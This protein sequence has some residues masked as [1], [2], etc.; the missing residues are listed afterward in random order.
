MGV[1]N[2]PQARLTLSR[3]GAL[4]EHVSGQNV[5]LDSGGMEWPTDVMVANAA[6]IPI[7]VI[8]DTDGSVTDTLLGA[9]ASAPSSCRTNS[10]TENVDSITPQGYITHAELILNGRCT[11][12]AAAQLQ[13]MQYKLERAIG[14]VLG[15]AWSQVNDNVFTGVPTATYNQA[16]HWPIM[17]PIDIICGPY[18]YQCLPNPFTLRPDDVASMVLLYPLPLANG[19]YMSLQGANALTGDVTFPDGGPMLGVNVLVKREIYS[20]TT[21]D[22]WYEVSGV[23]GPGFRRAGTSVFVTAGMS[24]AASQGTYV[25]LYGGVYKIAYIPLP[26]GASYDNLIVSTE[27]LNPLYVGSYTVGPYGAGMVSP[28]GTMGVAQTSYLVGE[29]SSAE[30]DFPVADAAVA[31]GTGTDGTQSAAAQMAATGWW[32]AMI[33]GYQHA[34]YYGMDVRPERSFTVEATAL[35]AN[36]LAT[37]NKMMPV[38]GVFG[39]ADQLWESPS[40]GVTPAAFQGWSLGTSAITVQTGQ[41]THVSIGV[42]DERGDGRPDFNYQGRMFYADAVE[43]ATVAS[44]GAT[45]TI[46]GMGF[47]AGNAVLVNGVAATVTSWTANALVATLPTMAAAGAS[48]GTALDVTVMDRGT[49]ATSTMYGALTYGSGGKLPRAMILVS[50]PAGVVPVGDVASPV[51]AVRVVLSDGVT[52]VV[53]DKVVFQVASG[54]A[55]FGACGSA[56]CAVYTDATGLAQSSVTPG[57]VGSLT[58]QAGDGTV[59][60]TATLTGQTK[61]ASMVVLSAPTGN[62]QAGATAGTSFTVQVFGADGVTGLGGHEIS[63]TVTQGSATYDACQAAVCTAMTD[64]YGRVSMNVTPGGVGAVTLQAADDGVMQQVSFNALSGS[65][66]LT[67]VS[68]PLANATVNQY[69]GVLNVRLIKPDGVTGDGYVGVN[70]A[71]PAGVTFSVCGRNVCTLPTDWSGLAGST[72]VPSKAGIFKITASYGT[73]VLQFTMVVTAPVQTMKLLS[74]PANGS[75]VGVQAAAPFT[76]QMI[77][78]DGVTPVSGSSV[79][80]SGTPGSALLS[81]CGYASC[82]VNTDGNGIVTTMVT[83]LLAGTIVLNAASLPAVAATSFTAVVP[84]ETMRVVTQP[85]AGLLYVGDEQSF[86]VQL[87]KPDGVNPD[88][89]KSVTFSVTNG[90]FSFTGCGNGPCAVTTDGNGL[91]AMT[92]VGVSAGAVSLSASYGPSGTVS[93]TVSFSLVQKPDVMRLVSVPA[94]PS[95]TGAAAA[96]PFAVQVMLSDGL[97]AAVGRNVT[98]S[99][100]NG[101]A[102]FAAC[103]GAATCV[104]VSDG[105]GIVSSAVTP[106]VAGS[107]G[108]AAVDG[109]ASQTGSFT[110]VDRPDI[111]QLVSAP[112]DGALVGDV[113]ATAF[114]VRVLAGDGVTVRSG[115]SVVLSISGGSAVLQACGGASCTIVTNALGIA[116]STVMPNAAG[117]IGLRAADGAVT[118]TASFIAVAKPDL[119]ALVSAPADGAWVGVAAGTAFVLRVLKADGVTPDPGQVV[120]LA[121]GAGGASYG[122]CGGSGCTVVTDENGYLTSTVTPLLAGTIG[123]T[124]TLGNATVSASFTAVTR[125]DV[126]RVVSVPANGS[127]VGDVTGVAFAVQVLQGDGVTPAVGRSVTVS[128]TNGSASLG[129][130]GVA[131]S[132]VLVSDANGMVSTTVTPTAAGVVGL[133]AADG[134][135]TQR[136]SFMAEAKPD[137]LTLVS[138]PANGAWVGVPAGVAFI[139]RV[140]KADGITPDVG[141]V[142]SLNMSGA[143]GNLGACGAGACRVVSDGNGYVSSLVTPLLAGTLTVSATL[144]NAAVSASFTAVNRPDVVKVVSSPGNGALVGDVAGVAFSVQVFGGDGVTPAVGKSVTVVVTNGSARL[145]ACGGASCV[146]TTDGTGMV[147]TR[148]MPLAAGTVGLLGSDGLVTASAAF[149]AVAKPDVLIVSQ[150]LPAQAYVGDEVV[151]RL[152]ML[153]ADGV[154]AVA[155]KSVV[156]MVT[157]GSAS[158]AGCAGV[159]SLLTDANGYLTFVVSAASAGAISLSGQEVGGDSNLVTMGFLAVVKPDTM[160]LVSGPTGSGYVGDAMGVPFRVQVLAGDGSAGVGRTVVMAVTAGG[161]VLSA[162]GG[163]VCTVVTD[164]SGMASTV[165]TPT[166]AGVVDLSATEGGNMVTDAFTAVTKAD[167]LQMVSGPGV[168]LHV[169]EV[170]GTALAVRV[171]LADGVTPA[172]GVKVTFS[173]SGRGAGV[174]VFGACGGVVCTGVSGADG[175]VSTE[176]TGAV[177]GAVT[178]VATADAGVGGAS[179][180]VGLQVVADVDSV[181]AVEATTY[182]AEGASFATTLHAVLVQNGAVAGGQGVV[183]SGVGGVAVAS[184]G[185]VS[186]GSGVAVMGVVLGPLAAGATGSVT[187]CAWTSVCGSF[188][189]VGVGGGALGVTVVSGGGQVVTQG[190]A[191]GQVGVQ[192]T[193]G[194]GHAVAGAQVTVDQTVSGLGVVCVGTGRCPAQPVLASAQSVGVSDGDGMV[195]VQALTLEGVSTQTEMAFSAGTQGF[196]TAVLTRQF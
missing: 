158:F 175:I 177:L 24:E 160:T 48:S 155:S 180:S 45:V 30:I 27:A 9:G 18:S 113:A 150:A 187:A 62:V 32:N 90:G 5:Y 12:T 109:L 149:T 144:G 68:A 46:T 19:H 91:A 82:M 172:A 10:V 128:V 71:A 40:L 73:Q 51:F 138:A 121:V 64:Y 80:I 70:F 182:V 178:L 115:I 37:T 114:A 99:V 95:F 94:S 125:P 153:L 74:A 66:T 110:V 154:T 186:D 132:C 151:G 81:I 129:G 42:A 60:Q 105:S 34:S 79:A 77:D 188:G 185:S 141:E 176:V 103:S 101:T 75:T 117:T 143:S 6:A 123:L 98:L 142:V 65:D 116:S 127:L 135:V 100:T 36:G 112:V 29:Y 47:R 28:S 195:W 97:T 7:A 14:R 17:H 1:W 69:S 20:T 164:G 72:V 140:L 171:V 139:V 86:S 84:A 191:L 43:P 31:C 167:L 56:S 162:C 131:A 85:G 130:C 53:G 89:G 63:F 57:A 35:D 119:L 87:L 133:M 136:V 23:S 170:S 189:V 147:S 13:E 194:G 161:A 152:R 76:V 111:L 26:A 52:P 148:V 49:G 15:L 54:T 146:L 118:Q 88:A 192:V 2:V 67:L 61:T 134:A 102:G 165:V 33:C 196:A 38:I 157:A 104:L 120:T 122:A 184:G 8:Y 58:V 78:V 156:L 93:Q 55:T 44:S 126:M 3:G 124:A 145:E 159:C 169:G 41:M 39:A 106:L 22:S 163:A 50:A 108:L 173:M 96:V 168:S 4:A 179:V 107:V 190:A 11:G 25:P 166:V 21:V 183:W 193:D 174:V 16:L 181:S 59:I 92:G 83:P 137:L